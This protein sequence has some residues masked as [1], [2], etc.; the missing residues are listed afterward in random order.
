MSLALDGHATG[1]A[2]SGTTVTASLT[3]TQPGDIIVVGVT[4]SSATSGMKVSS[5][6]GTGIN[7]FAVRKAL[8]LSGTG[9]DV[10]L[11]YGYA[12]LALSSVTITVTANHTIA[13]AALSVFGVSGGYYTVPGDP[14]SSIP[15]TATG[16]SSGTATVSGVSTSNANDMLIGVVGIEAATTETAGSGFTLIDSKTS[17]SLAVATQYEI[18]SATQSSISVAFGT[19][20]GGAWG[21]IADAIE[22]LPTGLFID[23][24]DISV[25]PINS[26]PGT[27]SITTL[28]TNDVI[29]FQSFMVSVG[30][31]IPTISSISS[32]NTTSWASR[33]VYTGTFGN[34]DKWSLEQ[35][36][37]KASSALT[38]ESLS[39]TYSATPSNANYNVFGVHGANL[40]TIPDA[41]ASLP[42]TGTGGATQ[43]SVSISTS[44]ANDMVI[45]C[46]IQ[47]GTV[48][49]ETA[50]S[51]FTLITGS[52]TQPVEFKVTAGTISSVAQTFGTTPP[53]NWAMLVDAIQAAA[54]VGS[55]DI[56]LNLP[57]LGW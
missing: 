7:N 35:W 45:A 37:G 15:A 27:A 13:A 20:T 16:S 32:T 51:G 17:T 30:S 50:G 33:K 56:F 55:A 23:G 54:V 8:A 31:A 22:A 46:M 10:E 57:M 5:I 24:V 11:W 14:N 40:T 49:N 34:G 28:Q 12:P 26:N 44:N 43:P 39:I 18:V 4:L 3:T 47:A 21:I 19:T 42:A 38:N 41:N 52:A 9:K 36:Y 6:S 29:V 2:T 53:T 48:S 1:S 25:N